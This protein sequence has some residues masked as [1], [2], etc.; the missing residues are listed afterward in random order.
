MAATVYRLSDVWDDHTHIPQAQRSRNVLL[1]G[2]HID[3]DGWLT[4][5]VNPHSYGVEG[6]KSAEGQAFVLMME[7]AHAVWQAAGEPGNGAA[8][9]DVSRLLTICTMLIVSIVL[10]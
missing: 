2:K 9:V 7:S 3:S 8:F 6:S 4:P 5:V 10:L 1:N